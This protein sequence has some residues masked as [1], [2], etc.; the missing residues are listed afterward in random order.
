MIKSVFRQMSPEEMYIEEIEGLKMIHIYDLTGSSK[1]DGKYGVTAVLVNYGDNKQLNYTENDYCFE[2]FVNKVFEVY[3]TS[4]DKTS[5]KMDDTTRKIME[6][7]ALPRHESILSKYYSAPKFDEPFLVNAS[8][9]SK[10]FAA[11]IEY[12]LVGL[13]KTMGTDIDVI[14]RKSGWRGSGRF[15]L[16]V[17]DSNRSVY[18]KV[19]ELN[20]STYSIK[21]NGFLSDNGDFL[22]NVALYDDNIS[23]TYLSESSRIEGSATFKFGKENLMEMHQ[24]RKDGEQIFYDVNSYENAF[25]EGKELKDFVSATSIELLPEDMKPCAV[26]VL[27]LGLTYILYDE[28]DTSDEVEVK[29]FCG[30]FLWE[31]GSC[32]DIRGWSMIKSV[33]TG[34]SIKSET[35]RMMNQSDNRQIIQTSLLTGTGS[36]YK[37]ELEGKFVIN[38]RKG[39]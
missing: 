29:T 8:T 22:I 37:K 18:Y 12:L 38:T 34:L 28:E 7:G 17:G 6:A 33:Q 2:L 32:A 1:P 27:P 39:E 24:I 31:N 21:L 13:Y 15:I 9:L 30:V 20:E 5:I 10:R 11:L 23:I 26:Y 4:D 16:R 19:F 36:R 35:F 3:N 14:D 25:E